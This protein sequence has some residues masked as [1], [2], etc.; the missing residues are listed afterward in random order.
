MKSIWNW[1]KSLPKPVWALLAAALILG[2]IIGN[3]GGPSGKEKMNA[4]EQTKDVQ[5]WTCSMHPQIKLPEPGQCPICFM[6]LIPLESEAEEDLGPREL[7]LSETAAKLAEIQ[8]E[9]VHRGRATAEIRLS[10]KIVPDERKVKTITAWAEGR[11]EKLFV[12]FT[13]TEVKAGDPLVELY[14]PELYA[15]QEELLQALRQA[16]SS[17]SAGVLVEAVREKLRQLGLANRQIRE[18]EERGVPSER[19]TIVSPISGV[20]IHKNA[21]EGIY[22]KRGSRIYTIADLS[23]VWAVLDAYEKDLVFLSEGQAVSFSAEAL[24]G[25]TFQSGIRF[26]DPVLDESTRAVRVRLNV[27]NPDMQ[28]KPGMFIR[29]VAEASLPSEEGKDPILVPASAVLKTGTR[30]VVY[31]RKPER[32]EPVFEGREVVLGPRAGDQYVVLA[33]LKEGESVV[34]RGNF[35]IDSAMQIQAKKSMMNPDVASAGR[36]HP[37]HAPSESGEKSSSEAGRSAMNAD[38]V[39]VSKAFR[40]TLTP[41]YRAYFRMQKALAADDEES[42]KKAGVDMRTALSGLSGMESVPAVWPDLKTELSGSLEHA[43]HWQ[44]MDAVRSA[45]E[46]ISNPVI[47]MERMFGQTGPDAV[48]RVFC[49]MAFDNRGAEWLQT[50]ST[51]SN[52]Y[53]GSKMPR[54]GEIKET[55]SPE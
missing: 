19:L 13:G 54:C 2:F 41:I 21:V 52:P 55:F 3:S 47:Q 46:K 12:D 23:E 17:E 32:E 34:V 7:K 37:G 9:T 15:A 4:S 33:G 50:D 40:H 31:V 51:I 1:L 8:T 24:P 45:F 5:W 10:G 30:A 16:D 48:Y 14:S 29:A 49:P 44:S 22:V 42:A 11:L 18:V 36:T 28:L 20:V 25:R 38:D 35:K 6:D 26:I 27:P 43:H 39:T 53:F